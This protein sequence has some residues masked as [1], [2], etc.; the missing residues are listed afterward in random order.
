MSA[1][2]WKKRRV[3]GSKV[4]ET[5]PAS[6]PSSSAASVSEEEQTHAAG[7]EGRRIIVLL[8]KAVLETTKTKRNDF[9]LLNC[10]DHRHIARKNS[11]DPSLYRPD[12]LHQVC[13]QNLNSHS[14]T[15]THTHNKR[16]RVRERELSQGT[17]S[18]PRFRVRSEVPLTPVP[19]KAS[20]LH[21]PT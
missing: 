4:E 14:N 13:A 10:D 19:H 17:C 2:N 8:D 21:G 20:V 7:A 6:V 3:D 1:K 18:D 16:V 9:E 5:T 12:I 15:R 11:L